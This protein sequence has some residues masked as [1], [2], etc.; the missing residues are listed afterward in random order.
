MQAKRKENNSSWWR[1]LANNGTSDIEENQWFGNSDLIHS[2]NFDATTLK[3][4]EKF[5]H[6]LLHL[7]IICNIF[8]KGHGFEMFSFY[9][10]QLIRWAEIEAKSSHG[11]LDLRL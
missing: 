3:L 11:I 10:L 6:P 5:D 1:H 7:F 8:A 4:A 2:A 9:S